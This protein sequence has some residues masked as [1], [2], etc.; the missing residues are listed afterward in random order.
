[1]PPG[2]IAFA[3]VGINNGKPYTANP[4]FMEQYRWAQRIEKNPAVYVN[5]AFPKAG[6]VE[7]TSG[8]YGSCPDE[9]DGWC[10]G[11][12]YGY[13]L[14]K[15]VV[16]RAN[17]MRVHPPIY[18]LDV[19]TGNYWSSD[20]Q[21]NSQVLRGAIAY[22]KEHSLAVGMYGT[23][24]QYRLIAGT[25]QSPGIPIWTA[26]AQGM[27]GASA[28]CNSGYA[29]AGGNVV[30]V[31]Y[32]DW[33]FDTNYICPGTETLFTHPELQLSAAPGPWGRGNAVTQQLPFWRVLPFVTN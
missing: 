25:W 26:G 5:T 33:G 11:Y 32:Y 22:F 27:E 31:Q 9:N 29:F 13:G 15:E 16:T 10:R 8:P 1:M 24:Y 14:A 12:N 30:M 18:W 23:P 21:A 17:L 19:E 28:R 3:I 2:P 4:C 6:A 7:A 20:V